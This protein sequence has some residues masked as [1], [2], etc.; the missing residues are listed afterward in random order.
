[1]EVHTAIP[2]VEFYAR[3]DAIYNRFRIIIQHFRTREKPHVQQIAGNDIRRTTNSSYIS[4]RRLSDSCWIE[5]NNISTRTRYYVIINV[6]TALSFVM[7][8]QIFAC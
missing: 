3:T 8:S 6:N 2:F 1:M 4:G 7:M 5:Y